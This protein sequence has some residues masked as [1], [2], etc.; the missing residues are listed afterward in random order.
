MALWLPRVVYG[1]SAVVLEPG[2][3]IGEWAYASSGVGG[4]DESGAGVPSV[5]EERWD[6]EVDVPWRFPDALY[7]A[8]ESYVHWAVSRQSHLL[9]FNASD[10]ATEY[11]VRL[12]A[13]EMGK[14]W[15]PTR[16]RDYPHVWETTFR[17]RSSNGMRF[18]VVLAA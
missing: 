10:A 14:R 1:P 8:V 6:Y 15:A 5:W 17:Y 7:G 16:R 12:I 9:R 4:F 13:P 2:E 3:P 11:A 18:A